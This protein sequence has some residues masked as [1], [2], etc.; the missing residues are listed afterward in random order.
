MS[1]YVCNLTRNDGKLI[2]QVMTAVM[3]LKDK[4]ASGK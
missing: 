2:V 4:K 1:R 3:T